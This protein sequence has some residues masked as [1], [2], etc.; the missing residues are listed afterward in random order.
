MQKLQKD[1]DREL[2]QHFIA[3]NITQLPS[4]RYIIERLHPILKSDVPVQSSIENLVTLENV[5]SELAK[6]LRFKLTAFKFEPW[7]KWLVY[8]YDRTQFRFLIWGLEADKSTIVSMV[9]RS[10][11]EALKKLYDA[12]E[13]LDCGPIKANFQSGLVCTHINHMPDALKL[14]LQN[15]PVQQV[16]SLK[17]WIKKMTD[18]EWDEIK[19]HGFYTSKVDPEKKNVFLVFKNENTFQRASIKIPVQYMITQ[20]NG[21]ERNRNGEKE[22]WARELVVQTPT[23]ITVND[24]IEVY[25]EGNIMACIQENKE[26]HAESY[27]KLD[28]LPPN[29]NEELLRNCLHKCGGPIPKSVY[30]GRTKNNASGWA[31]VIFRN[32]QERNEAANIYNVQLCRDIFLIS[33]IGKN[34]LMKQKSVRT[35]VTKNDD[36]FA[37]HNRMCTAPTNV[38]RITTVNR[39]AARSIYSSYSHTFCWK[40][41]SS[42]TV[43]ILRTDLYPNFDN[44]IDNICKKFCVQVKR[45][46]I[47]NFGQRCTFNNGDP[48]KTSLAASMLAQTFTPINIKLNTERQKQLFHELEDIGEIQKWALEL[49][50]CINPNRYFTNIEIHGT[51]TAQGK[52][53]RRIADYSESFDKRF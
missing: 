6:Q 43:T 22:T 30:V 13:L 28:T 1:S 42:A 8:H 53:M 14:H 12:Y 51:Q 16:G 15:V 20:R 36:P 38:F 34:G 17:D 44:T 7:A 35:T 21:V 10:Y 27:V 52:L 26:S 48:Q 32:D 25:G 29:I 9:Q 5:G 47:A 4:G 39:E 46:N 33:F 11:D 2:Y 37:R 19:A 45:K 23:N 50:L 31:K 18:I 41:D 3:M 49:C 24:I 40:M